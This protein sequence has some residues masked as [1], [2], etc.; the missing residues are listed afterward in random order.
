[1]AVAPRTDKITKNWSC[2]S[3]EKRICYK[4]VY[5]IMSIVRNHEKPTFLKRAWHIKG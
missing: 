2:V 3:E 4:M 1:M 5:Y